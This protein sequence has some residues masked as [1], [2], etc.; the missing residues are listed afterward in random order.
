[1]A[2][3]YKNQ[4]DSSVVTPPTGGTYT[5]FDSA[6]GHFKKKDDA[7]T[8]TDLEVSAS[9]VTSFNGRS[10]AV[11]PIA[12]DYDASLIDFTPAGDLVS[13]NVQAAIEE[14]DAEKAPLSHVGSGGVSEHAVATGS[15]AGFM[16]PSD[17][18]KLA[19]IG[20]LAN[21]ISV[22]GF[23]GV[24]VLTKSDVGLG[25]VDNT[26]DVNKPVSTAQA[27][28]DAAVQA[29]AIQRANH[30]GTQLAATIS[31]FSTAADAR[32]ALQKGA[33][34][35]I[36]P[37]DGSSK[38]PST[39][40]PAI[41]ITDTFVVVSQ[42]AMLALVAETGDVAVRTD[43]NKTFILKGTNPAVLGDWQELLTPTDAVTSVN[44]FTGVVVLTKSD[45]GLGNVDNTSDANKP[46]S[47][48]QATALAGKANTVHTHVSTDITNFD[49][50]AQDAMGGA[51]LNTAS[52]LT[53][54]NDSLNQFSW[55][56]LPA[57]VDHNLLLNYVANQHIDHTS[58]TMGVTANGGIGGGGTI[59]ANR[60][61]NLDYIN[62][63]ALSL[64]TDRMDFDDRIAIYDL[65]S[66]THK[67]VTFKDFITQNRSFINRAYNESDDFNIDG[68][69][70]LVDAGAGTGSSVQSGSYGVG[71]A[72]NALGVSQ[73]DTGTTATGRR[74]LSCNLAS[75]VTS[76]GRLRFS[77]RFAIEQLSTGVQTFTMYIGFIDSNATGD[78]GN[79]AYFKYTDGVNA[80]KWQ[81]VTASG[82]TRTAVDS[83]VTA[84]TSYHAF[85]TEIN[86]AGTSV[87]F[88]IDGVLVATTTSN[89]PNGTLAQAFGYGW[90]IEKSVGTTQV[91]GSADWY[92]YELERTSAR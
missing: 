11:V 77:T 72:A 1:M 64:P 68:N 49:E 26:S 45:V 89:L 12:S 33:A 32:I 74:S 86:E 91:N 19:G 9:G 28:A 67:Y 71:T 17:F 56:V 44:G 55:T 84:D 52:I 7:G 79:G 25:N 87:G 60:V 81:C 47:T 8:V 88:Y 65:S 69:A 21:V 90:K 14:L 63:V 75:L 15:A 43:L 37:L 58:V 76:K 80:G 13:T 57:G 24:V 83:G 92:Y 16:S 18:T 31:D 35:G 34:S 78:M 70:R 4:S 59:A 82:G 62:L 41:A 66:T 85:T 27:A 73:I 61:F 39:Y 23:T 20:A 6:D 22:N 51:L 54:Y 5:F 29:F 40:L 53:A 38:I 48:A 2:I 42:V 30:T 46:V 3:G 10:G 50:A 36:A